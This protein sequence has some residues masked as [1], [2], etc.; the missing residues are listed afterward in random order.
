MGSTTEVSKKTL[1]IHQ[2][3]TQALSRFLTEI[4]LEVT[5]KL[6]QQ[7]SAAFIAS[8]EYEQLS[9]A[10]RTSHMWNMNVL[11]DFF[12]RLKRTRVGHQNTIAARNQHFVLMHGIDGDT[13][14]FIS[15][16]EKFHLDPVS[17]LDSITYTQA[18]TAKSDTGYSEIII[19]KSVDNSLAKLIKDLETL[20]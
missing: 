13:F 2:L 6:L 12:I 10:E 17:K 16:K 5:P 20:F 1:N 18:M 9:A 8:E 15:F 14:I 7:M 3:D 11:N 4:N 19:S